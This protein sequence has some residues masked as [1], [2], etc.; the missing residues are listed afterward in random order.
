MEVRIP[1]NSTNNYFPLLSFSRSDYYHSNFNDKYDFQDFVYK[2]PNS[3]RGEDLS[4]YCSL[5]SDFR[6]K[7][8]K[9]WNTSIDSCS[10]ITYRTSV[11]VLNEEYLFNSSQNTTHF[12]FRTKLYVK[13]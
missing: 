12:N 3:S 11:N 2:Y 7:T 5:N 4:Y 10:Y 9:F 1:H 8:N 13:T 6:Y